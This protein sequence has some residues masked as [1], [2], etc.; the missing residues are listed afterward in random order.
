[1]ATMTIKYDNRN[2]TVTNLLNGLIYSGIIEPVDAK[3]KRIAE[4]ESALREARE[5]A[6]DIAINGTK[7]YKTLDELLEEDD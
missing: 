1:M 2:K 3:E 7:G 4:F 5:M 6:K